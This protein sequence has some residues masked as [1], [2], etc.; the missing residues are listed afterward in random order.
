MACSLAVPLAQAQ[1]APK[2][3]VFD[4][5]RL[6]EADWKTQQE[7]VK[8]AED[9]AKTRKELIRMENEEMASGRQVETLRKQ[10]GPLNASALTGP[11]VVNAGSITFVTKSMTPSDY[12][13]PQAAAAADEKERQFSTLQVTIPQF[14][15]NSDR[16]RRHRIDTFKR[17]M[18]AEISR[19]AIGIAKAHGGMILLDK[20]GPTLVGISS[21]VYCDPSLDI[22]DEVLAAI[23]KDRPANL[24]KPPNG[25]GGGLPT[26]G[27]PEFAPS[28][29]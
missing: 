20:S 15:A 7:E 9:E 4:L 19:V 26:I 1:T 16:E 5:T 25:W 23:N 22:T 28:T 6:F 8:L 18:F 11:G 2:I 3:I 10:A 13:N 21:V 29:D 14:E 27:F 12:A 24:P 17:L